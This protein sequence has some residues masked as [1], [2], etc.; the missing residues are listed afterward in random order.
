MGFSIAVTLMGLD[1]TKLTIILSAFGVGNGFGLQSIVSNFVSGLIMLFERPLREGDTIEVGTNWAQ[2]KKIGLRATV[3][4]TF[5]QADIIIPNSDLINNQVTNWTLSNRQVRLSVPVGVAYGSDLALVEATLLAC[6]RGSDSVLKS[7]EP[8]VLFK[9]LGDSAL[10]FELRVW[11]VDAD[12]RPAVKS[13]LYKDIDSAFREAGIEIPYPQRVLHVQHH[14]TAVLHSNPDQSLK[15][16]DPP[17][18]TV[19]P[20]EEKT[21]Q[22]AI[23]PEKKPD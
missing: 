23:E 4:E 8:K 6:A 9:E 13:E 11:V 7:P 18:E 5:E 21:D 19:D 3:V 20:V 1:F 16:P 12:T 14:D 15:E 17:P 2:I 22:P 10:G